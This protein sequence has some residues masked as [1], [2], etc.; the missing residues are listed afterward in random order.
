[1]ALSQAMREILPFVTIMKEIEF[2][3]KL[4]GDA[5]TVLCIIF[6]KLVMHVTVYGDNQGS[7]ALAISLQ[8]KPLTNHIA[9]KYHHFRSFVANGDIKIKHVNTK[10]KITDI[11]TKPLDYDSFGYIRYQ[12]N[13][14]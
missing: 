4:Q 9:I 12:R 14:L 11:F 8:M 1:M 3:L 6:E 7:V 13:G 10:E 5:L 2:V